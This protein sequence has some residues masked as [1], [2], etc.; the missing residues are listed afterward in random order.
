MENSA[1]LPMPAGRE[2]GIFPSLRSDELFFVT[3]PFF[4]LMGFA[5][6]VTSV[7]LRVP[8]VMAPDKPMSAE[9]ATEMI[10]ATRPTAAAFPPSILTDMVN[11]TSSVEALSRLKLVYYAGG[12][13]SFETGEL[14]SKKTKVLNFLGSS[15]VG[16]INTLIPEHPEDW[17]YFEWNQNYGIDMQPV[18]D[19][20]FEMVMRRSET[21]DFNGIFHTFPDLNEYHTKDLFTPHPTRPSLWRFHGRLDDVIVLSN[22][23]KFNPVTM[24]ETIEGHPLVSRAVVVGQGR[25]QSAL[26]IEPNWNLWSE[27]K[28]ENELIE[29]IWPAVQQAN[30]VGPAHGRI[31]RAKIG[32]SSPRKPFK[33]TAK[34]STQRRFVI[35]DYEAEINDI[36]AKSDYESAATELPGDATLHNVQDYVRGVVSTMLESELADQT[37]FYTAGFDSLL[38]MQLSK[39]LQT[40]IRS[41]HPAESA[42]ITPQKIYANPTV[43]QLSQFVYAILHGS[44]ENEVSR[45]EKIDNLIEKY[46]TGLPKQ[47][48]NIGSVEKHAVILTGSTGSLGNY[49]LNLLV[50]DAKVFKVYCLNRSDARDRQI[51]SFHEKGLAFDSNAEA[52]VEFLTASFGAESLGLDSSKYDEMVKSVDTIIHNAWRVDFNISVDSFADV[53]IQSVRRFVDF[54]LQSAHRAHIHFVSSVS[55]I[56][57][58]NPANGSIPETP[59]EDCKVVLPQGYGESKHVGERICLE[60]SR[61][62][63]VP[64]TIHRVGQIAGPTTEKGM[65]SRQEWLPTII[66]TSKAIGRVP[67]TLG[68]MPIDWIPVVSAFPFWENISLTEMINVG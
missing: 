22:G 41:H 14:L 20:L 30:H 6:L 28:P 15:E 10:N 12:P 59:L 53:H 26:L 19:G 32:V 23:E 49:L 16:F 55:T 18:G 8:C 1:N 35:Q 31:M 33:T 4:H 11:Y 13:L 2:S 57:A 54:S 29:R 48:L 38:T 25:F 64:A 52:K 7:F 65:W 47:T 56:G 39:L 24:E 67:N 34:G 50:N 17:Q 44:M 61:R 42:L 68:S 60:A 3:T 43:E 27:D 9:V 40:A 58:W 21:R 63:G 5:A 51:K 66:A 46:T 62:A 45:T 36:Y 37:D